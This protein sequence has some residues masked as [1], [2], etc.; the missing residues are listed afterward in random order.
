MKKNLLVVSLV[1][2]FAMT[3]TGCGGNNGDGTGV[4]QSDPDQFV[5]LISWTKEGVGTHL[6]AGYAT[7]PLYNFALEGLA[8]F[9]RTTDEVSMQLASKFEHK[10]KDANGDIVTRVTLR[11]DAKW[12]N[13]DDFTAQD[14]KA[15]YYIQHVTITNYL[16]K[17]EVVDSKT[18]DFYWNPLFDPTDQ[19]KTLLLA[20]DR[21]GSV[22][23]SEF[24]DI[25]DSA[26]SLVNSLPV[27]TSSAK[28]AS[29]F[30]RR[31]SG[32]D[33]NNFSS[34]YQRFKNHVCNWFLATGP[35]ILDKF[36][37]TQMILKKNENWYNAD[38][39]KFA[40]VKAINGEDDLTTI[41]SQLQAGN[42]DYQNFCPPKDVID[43]VVN[44]NEN[45]VH[46]KMFDPGAVG[47]IFN[48]DK[49]I[50]TDRAR[51]AFQYVFNRDEIK[52]IANPYGITSYYPMLSMCPQEANKD[53]SQEGLNYLK[54]HCTFSFNQEKAKSLLIEDGWSFES[55]RWYRNGSRV[56]LT[57]GYDGS[58]P[59][60]K[61]AAE[62][63][64]SELAS[65]G[66]KVTLKRSADW[67]TF[68][69]V[70]INTNTTVDCSVAWT[71]LN[72]TF[73]VPGGSFS[74]MY[75]NP[76]SDL[77]HLKRYTVSDPEYADYGTTVK[78]ELNGLDDV[79]FKPSSIYST[80]WCEKDSA[81]LTKKVDNLVVGLAKKN[82]GIQFYQSVTGAFW[83]ISKIGGF[84]MEDAVK[85]E[86][87]YS[88]IP[89]ESDPYFKEIA[90][91]NFYYG[92]GLIITDG[93]L[94]SRH[95]VGQETK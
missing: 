1:A 10:A 69:N 37:S 47:M 72:Q 75:D 74:Y 82:Y 35:F 85:A 5:Y 48:L 80:L 58:N 8:R 95:Y 87:N 42:I 63:A 79:A 13:G 89:S 24:K 27:L 22:K 56:E 18:V 31:L 34:I 25:I 32:T 91:L 62:A 94:Y 51:E 50:W 67:I 59:Y 12:H 2:L 17:I 66:I 65:F 43:S 7:G 90:K 39:I 23:Y 26:V 9:V 78:L 3:C 92:E 21:S 57:L 84:P 76:V 53:L 49:E 68:Y 36:S 29:P 20:Q 40:T 11:P 28:V 15:Y 33:L 6:G 73:M 70:G 55:N 77:L 4:N 52:N 71:D 60:F 44:S 64:A 38:K 45:I 46:Y 41:Y 61:G 81:A 83:N 86:N 14:V 54:D 16:L 30:G 19:V 88:Y 93:T